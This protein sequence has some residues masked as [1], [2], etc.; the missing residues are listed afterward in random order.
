MRE[1]KFRVWNKTDEEMCY[2]LENGWSFGPSEEVR[3]FS[4]EDVFAAQEQDL[5]PLQ[6]TGLKDKNG[7]EIYEGDVIRY[8]KVFYTDC[9]REEIEEVS[10][11]VIGS[12]YYAEDLYPGIQFEDGTGSLFWPG[13]IDSDEFEVI[14]N[15]H[16]NPELLEKHHES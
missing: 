13:T 16:E 12:F 7:R 10:D 3:A 9:S 6:Y 15:I 5:I 1:I 8:I 4:W 11:P 14:G 2:L